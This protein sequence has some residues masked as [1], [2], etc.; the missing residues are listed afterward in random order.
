M[1][2]EA[3]ALED[4]RIQIANIVERVRPLLPT[5]FGRYKMT[6]MGRVPGNPGSDVLVSED[7]YS[8]LTEVLTRRFGADPEPCTW[9]QYDQDGEVWEPSC[10][11]DSFALNE[12]SPLSNGMKFC[13]YCGHPLVQEPWRPDEDDDDLTDVQADAQTLSGVYGPE[14]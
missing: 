10:P 2:Q 8:G 14:E 13:C 9:T 6:F 5:R 3:E 4:L 12:G 1:S 11:G 7:D